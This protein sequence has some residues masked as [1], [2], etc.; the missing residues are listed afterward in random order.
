MPVPQRLAGQPSPCLGYQMPSPPSSA[1]LPRGS[2]L[3]PRPEA[4]LL[5]KGVPFRAAVHAFFA[6]LFLGF[7]HLL[8]I[9]LP[10]PLSLS[11]FLNPTFSSS[12]HSPTHLEINSSIT[13]LRISW[14]L[15]G[16]HVALIVNAPEKLFEIYHQD[17]LI[18]QVPIKGL[19]EKVLPF[20]RYVTLI[21]QEARSELRRLQMSRR[22]L[23]Q[24]RLWA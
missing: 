5:G 4:A 17:I 12:R 14:A 7:S 16:Q 11:T 1:C 10:I 8:L 22:S 6:W 19:H 18:K 20:D 23:R 3:L 24:L 15:A 2:T 13:S 21:K 9:L